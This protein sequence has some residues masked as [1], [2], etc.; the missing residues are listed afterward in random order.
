MLSS[1]T[2]KMLAQ[3]NIKK[4]KRLAFRLKSLFLLKNMFRLYFSPIAKLEPRKKVIF[5]VFVF[6]RYSKTLLYIIVIIQFIYLHLSCFLIFSLCF[7]SLLIFSL[8][9][10]VY[11]FS[12]V[13]VLDSQFPVSFSNIFVDILFSAFFYISWLTNGN[14]LTH[15]N[16]MY[17]FFDSYNL[18]SSFQIF[19]G[20]KQHNSAYL[21]NLT[22]KIKLT[23]KHCDSDTGYFYFSKQR[24]G[25][26][27]QSTTS[28]TSVQFKTWDFNYC[29][30]SIQLIFEHVFSAHE[31]GNAK[32]YT[33]PRWWKKMQILK[34]FTLRF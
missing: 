27:I 7:F 3:K 15:C 23:P 25:I 24:G 33:A 22:S 16:I 12:P 8:L 26:C 30:I 20:L 32:A 6:W 1:L 34:H 2:W 11:R 29:F 10:V 9:C 31:N 14:I 21:T 13:A 19:T 4:H 5:E 28:N 17:N 18:Q